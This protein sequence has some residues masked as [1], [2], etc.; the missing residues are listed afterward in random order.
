MSP[1]DEQERDALRLLDLAY[2]QPADERIAFIGAQ[3]S[4][5][6]GVRQ[7]ALTLLAAETEEAE[8]VTG[9]ALVDAGAGTEPPQQV[10]PWKI[11]PL[12]GRGGMGAVYK[13]ERVT[14]DFEQ[15]V[16]VKFVGSGA[17]NPQLTD[18]LRDE[19][20][21]LAGL[22]HPNIS[23]LIDGGETPDGTPYLVTE[24][25]EGRT[26][27]H[28]VT[29]GPLTVS[30]RLDV[31]KDVLKGMTYAH[32]NGVV[33]RDLSPAN[34]LIRNDGVVKI[35]DFGIA[36]SVDE[37][38]DRTSRQSVTEGFTAPERVAGKPST[39]LA[40]IYSLG[41]ILR[42]ITKDTHHRHPTDL[43]AVVAKAT[44][45]DPA[46][47]YTSVDL[48][49]LD[50][51][52]YRTGHSVHAHSRYLGYRFKR[53][54]GRHPLSIASTA[55]V[56]L[57]AA[58]AFIAMSILYVRAEQAEADALARFDSLRELSRTVL[59]DVYDTIERIPLTDDAQILVTDLG[60]Q[61]IEELENDPR[62]P[63]SLN[64]EIAA[65][66]I[67][68]GHILADSNKDF[69]FS[70]DVADAYWTEAEE[71][72]DQLLDQNPDDL[73]ALVTKA[74][75][76]RWRTQADLFVRADRTAALENYEAADA[77]LSRALTI[78]PQDREALIAH[79]AI[80]SAKATTLD[81]A[82]QAEEA[83]A[84]IEGSINTLIALPQSLKDRREFAM[85]LA[86]QRRTLG[87]ILI[88]Q[89]TPEQAID[90]LTDSLADIDRAE[91]AASPD[92]MTRR[93]RSIAHWRRAYAKLQ[94]GDYDGAVDDYQRAITITKRRL[95][96]DPSNEDAE[97]NR[98]AWSAELSLPLSALKRFEE[99]KAALDQAGAWY[100]KRY[101]D[102]PTDPRR[103]RTMLVHNAQLM[104]LH[105]A[106]GDDQARCEATAE[107]VR[108]ADEMRAID[109]LS[110]QDAT[111]IA[112]YEEE[113][114]KCT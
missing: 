94:T 103:I 29:E 36:K 68:L 21:L 39:T 108:F 96:I 55:A 57:L 60:R 44:A 71:R 106:A 64:H 85:A 72:L 114:E 113:L 27:Q 30:E 42:W 14:G 100:L 77:L 32:Q 76:I 43:D 93:A 41:A 37:T 59:F 70:P 104:E 63:T 40:D 28:L 22:N 52:R 109:S 47:R 66:A 15:T 80:Q 8:L 1:T 88:G 2:D 31:F 51:E 26:L 61:Y 33:H 87:G 48:L 35:I 9:G 4:F 23:Q 19:R 6:E 53:F 38:E 69:F 16:A 74:Q 5:S 86:N 107:L 18:R 10:G 12:I 56:S 58:G 67:Q 50:V 73:R 20:R 79:A 49:A 25:V 112:P 111:A 34:V 99:A 11:G 17:K 89:G 7:R 62:A 46:D 105:R 92:R 24:L 90:V 95:A 81:I 83:R 98:V 102:A 65:G 110:A 82:G 3:T 91:A 54:A 13:A 45:E 97:Y 101:E 84:A 75:L 78:D